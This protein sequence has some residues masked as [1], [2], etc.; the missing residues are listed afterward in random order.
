[1]N[2]NSIWLTTSEI[3]TLWPLKKVSEPLSLTIKLKFSDEL[4]HDTGFLFL[5]ALCMCLLTLP[6]IYKKIRRRDVIGKTKQFV[7]IR[8][9]IEG[10]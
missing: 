10:L 4:V 9:N 8:K 2:I 6:F 7:I 5:S 1:M 3:F